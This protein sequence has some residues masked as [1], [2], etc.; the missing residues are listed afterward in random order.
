M[1]ATADEPNEGTACGG[2]GVI[3]EQLP[4]AY[5][6]DPAGCAADALRRN[7][8]LKTRT[9]AIANK[10]IISML[11]MPAPIPNLESSAAI[12]Y[13]AASPASGPSQLRLGAATGAPT[14]ADG[15]VGAA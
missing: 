13:P 4:P 3:A 11:A 14:G 7:S 9:A 10:A 15:A 2:V 5:C 1:A 12:P 8:H 6:N